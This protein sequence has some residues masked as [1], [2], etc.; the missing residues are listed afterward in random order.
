VTG[1]L[2]GAVIR[3]GDLEVQLDERLPSRSA[4]VFRGR[5]D[6]SDGEVAVKITSTS[7]RTLYRERITLQVLR[8]RGVPVPRVLTSGLLADG[9]GEVRLCLVL[10]FLSGAG[11]TTAD[12]YR[13]MGSRLAELREHGLACT[14]LARLS[15]TVLAQRHTAGVQLLA[16]EFGPARTA[17]LGGLRIPVGAL[18][19]AHGDPSPENFVDGPSGGALIDFGAAVHAP[20]GLDL[21]RAW[22]TAQLHRGRP[23]SAPLLEGYAV[24]AG[25]LPT[26]LATWTAVA[27]TQLAVWRCR[28]RARP[29]VPPVA[30]VLNLLD[31]LRVTGEQQC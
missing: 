26:D 6:R 7:D 12:G 24:Q 28:H 11:P 4:T 18:A 15:T 29:E 23:A 10:G 13:R 3:I 9:A 20:T 8:G 5:T 27:A 16:D 25:R 1:A 19:L 22:V 21:G 30:A 2:P 31:T 17:W 14:H